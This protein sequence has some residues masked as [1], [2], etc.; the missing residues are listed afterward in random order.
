[1]P[2]ENTLSPNLLRMKSN[3]L[4]LYHQCIDFP[5]G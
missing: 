2:I 5:R 1:M 3:G 4:K